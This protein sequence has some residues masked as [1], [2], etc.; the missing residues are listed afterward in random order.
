M[1]NTITNLYADAF[2]ALDVVSREMVGFIPAVMRDS[3]VERA[4]INQQIYFPI[5]PTSSASAITPG[6]YAPDTGDQVIGNDSLTID[7]VY[8]VPFRWQ[9]AERALVETGPG[10]L[11]I[12]QAQIAQAMRVLV[13]AIETDLGELSIKASRAVAPNGTNLFDATGKLA[14][15]SEAVKI[16]TDNGAPLADVHAVLGTQEVHQM[17]QLTQLTNVNEAGN[18]SFLRQGIL[19]N[20]FGANLHQSAQIYAPTAGT[21]DASTDTDSSAYS[22]GDTVITLGTSGTGTI[23]AGD[24][25]TFSTDTTNQYVVASGDADVS[26]G[27]TITLAAPGLRKALAATATTIAVANVGAEIRHNVMFS[28][29]AIML[30]TRLPHDE[31]G[32]AAV[33][34]I[35]VVDPRSGLAFEIRQYAQYHRMYYEVCVAW[36]TKAIKP[37][38]MALLVD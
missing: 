13:N 29:D 16:L 35:P 12:Q 6:L 20:I 21:A 25:I 23:K 28:R 37:A 34:K 5:A 30:A 22:V 17:R 15:L 31:G 19:S 2:A 38:H 14:D 18:E 7:Q 8:K 4:A 9:S 26:N 10:F 11:T 27:G 1:S 3:S 36:G 33:A 32:D 24:V